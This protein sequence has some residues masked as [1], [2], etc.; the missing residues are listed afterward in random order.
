MF[1][2]TVLQCFCPNTRAANDSYS[3]QS[4]WLN[5]ELSAYGFNRY[6]SPDKSQFF[7][8]DDAMCKVVDFFK[9]TGYQPYVTTKQVDRVKTITDVATQ[10]NVDVL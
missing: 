4:H 3:P 7:I 6:T 8:N 10:N 2:R 1:K 5:K 9:G